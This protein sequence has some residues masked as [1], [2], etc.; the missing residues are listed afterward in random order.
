MGKKTWARGLPARAFG[1]GV[2]RMRISYYPADRRVELE[3]RDDILGVVGYGV[4]TAWQGRAPYV[5][6]ALVP[7]GPPV[8]EVIAGGPAVSALRD[9][10][11]YA[12]DDEWLFAAVTLGAGGSIASVAAEAYGSIL[13]VAEDEGYGNLIRAWQYF[14]DIHAADEGLERYRQFNR[15]RHQALEGYLARGGLRPAATCI[16]TRAGDLTLHV[17]ARRTPGIAIENPRQ[18]C[19]YR[20]PDTYGPRPPDFVRAMKVAGGPREW[21]WISGTAAIVGHESQAPGDLEAQAR[22]TFTNLDAVV[23]CAG[24]GAQPRVLAAKV[25]VRGQGAVLPPWPGS[26]RSAPTLI[27]R[28]D[29]CRAELALEIEAVVV[30]GP[31]N[32][33]Q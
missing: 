5:A 21:L 20:Y 24:L 26:W 23:A 9:G 19:A 15:G 30:G 33:A 12:Y 1:G 7:T 6:T 10:V 32:E 4:T 27:L 17:L 16:G 11:R 18:V 31:Q 28:G 3:G 13:R 29:I 25:Y 22:E 8:Y 2:E 14:P